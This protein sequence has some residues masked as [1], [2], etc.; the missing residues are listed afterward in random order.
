MVEAVLHIVQHLLVFPTRDSPVIA[1][2]AARLDR[3]SGTRGSPVSV[4]R[5]TVLNRRHPPDRSL[6]RGSPILVALGVI[7][8]ITFVEASICLDA[9]GQRFGNQSVDAFL[10]TLQDFLTFEIAAISQDSHL[11]LTEASRPSL[12]IADNC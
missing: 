8:E 6:S 5:E 1:R 2:C 12:A 11:L 7:N 10:R 4:Q 9:R 3:T